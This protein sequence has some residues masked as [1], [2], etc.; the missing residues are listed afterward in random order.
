MINLVAKS[1]A[2]G[3][4]P[5][6]NA[7]CTLSEL[8]LG[9]M[10]S[11]APFKGQNVA[12]EKVLGAALPTPGHSVTQDA[13]EIVWF[14]QSQFLVIGADMP[15]G[16]DE[17]AAMSD[18]SDAWCALLFSGV[19]VEEVLARLVPVDLR[20]KNFAQGAALRSQLGHM[21]LHLTRMGPQ[22]FR[23]MSFRSMAGTMVHEITRALD[24]FAARG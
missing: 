11:L 5:Y 23:V 22:S 15:A 21:P 17:L 14:S 1:P 7:G 2:E 16:L 24:F 4:L 3:M 13:R 9:Q 10:T 19:N 18:Q 20:E 12:I 8:A 6:T